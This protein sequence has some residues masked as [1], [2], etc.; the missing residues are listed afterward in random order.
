MINHKEELDIKSYKTEFNFFKIFIFS[1]F[2]FIIIRLWFLQVH[3]GTDF[4]YSSNINR[5]KKQVLL[6]PRGFLLDR[7]DR[8]LSGNKIILELKINLN[9]VDNLAETLQEIAKII[10]W[11]VSKIE[12]RIEQQKIRYGLFHPLTIKK[13]LSLEETYKLKLLHW[14]ISGVYIQESIVRTYPLKEN[15]SQIIGF[16]GQISKKEMNSLKKKKKPYYQEEIL[17]KSGLEKQYD[18]QLRGT[19]GVS[20]VEVDAYNRIAEKTKSPFYFKNREPVQG[21]NLELTLDKD[22]QESAWKAME[23]EDFIGPRKGSVIVMKTNGEILAWLSKPSF[24]P[25]IFSLELNENL[26]NQFVH[27]SPKIFLN[28]GLQE[29]YSPGSALKPFIALAALQEGI[30]N[31]ETIIHSKR[32]FRLGG[33]NFHESSRTGYG[34]IT[35]TQALERSSNIFFYKVGLD[36]GI[37]RIIKYLKLF[38]FGSSTEVD[39]PGE[40]NGFVPTK[41]WKKKQFEESWQLGE[42]LHTSIGQGYLSVTLIQ[43]A[44]AYNIIATEGLIVKP[45][46]RKKNKQEAL[47]TL[48]DRI[49]R[50]HFKLISKSLREIVEGKE[51]TARWWR[52]SQ[53]SF[54]GKT[55]T[56]QV[57]ALSSKKI[58]N[59]CRQLDLN[60]RHHGLFLSFAPADKPEIVVAVLTENSCSGS[61]GSVPIARDII[62]SYYKKYLKGKR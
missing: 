50:K 58:H 39:L 24:D 32:K 38:G 55:G 1:C 34:K 59:N 45:F 61:A 8:V 28:K 62:K 60:Q 17:G 16:V 5:F 52:S 40:I 23:R 14:N 21:T 15:A 56:S 57:I 31:E 25:N 47:D 11:P 9:Y 33:R 10:Q 53:F 30:I 43:L 35:L 44:V 3:H 18:E 7:E 6:A 42:T 46:L 12:A 54:A 2:I 19:P 37:N 51:G 26:W 29:H 20:L 27:R 49:Q 36:L 4:K 48:T 41:K 22:I 13:N